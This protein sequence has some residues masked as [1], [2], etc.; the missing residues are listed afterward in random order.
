MWVGRIKVVAQHFRRRLAM[1]T[2]HLY[3]SYSVFPGSTPMTRMVLAVHR[4]LGRPKTGPKQLCKH[5][6]I[7]EN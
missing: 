6:F 2:I 7:R 5:F 4:C 1:A 3:G